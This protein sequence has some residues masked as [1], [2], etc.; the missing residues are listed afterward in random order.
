MPDIRVTHPHELPVDEARRRLS[1]FADLLGK[2]G[3]R[4]DWRGSVAEVAGVP[5][6][7][8]RI[9]IHPAEIRVNVHVSRMI[10]LMGLDPVKLEGTVRRRLAESFPSK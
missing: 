1:G 5:G 8:G 10:T 9:E 6:V 3:V 4:L 7:S 2:Y